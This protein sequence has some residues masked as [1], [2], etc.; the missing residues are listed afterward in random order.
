MCTL[1][2]LQIGLVMARL[3]FVISPNRDSWVSHRN[4]TNKIISS[5][6]NLFDGMRVVPLYSLSIHWMGSRRSKTALNRLTLTRI[7]IRSIKSMYTLLQNI[8]LP[9]SSR[10]ISIV[11]FVIIAMFVPHYQQKMLPLMA[12]SAE[13]TRIFPFVSLLYHNSLEIAQIARTM[14][15]SSMWFA[16][17][18]ILWPSS[19]IGFNRM[20]FLKAPISRP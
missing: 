10:F 3:F 20:P 7:A 11:L 1:S 6:W 17:R 14:F 18:Q 9:K 16:M 2:Q 8:I 15:V 12:L 4:M 5:N 19:K 13:A